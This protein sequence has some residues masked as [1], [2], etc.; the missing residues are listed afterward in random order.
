VELLIGLDVLD[1][2]I[3]DGHVTCEFRFQDQFFPIR[4]HDCS[5]EPIA[6]LQYHLVGKPRQGTHR[7]EQAEQ[8]PC[9]T[10]NVPPQTKDVSWCISFGLQ[11]VRFHLLHERL[12]A[13][14]I[15]NENPSF[16]ALGKGSH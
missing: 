13:Q 4:F 3:L 15:K 12:G 10:H 11:A 6:I 14:Q 5:S 7:H 2:W 16:E 9:I 1:G 8:K